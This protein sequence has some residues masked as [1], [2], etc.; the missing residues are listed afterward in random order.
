VDV[1]K[2]CICVVVEGDKT[3]R[4]LNYQLL[5]KARELADGLNYQ[6]VAVWAGRVDEEELEC[7]CS[8][9][10]D[11]VY[12]GAIETDDIRKIADLLQTMLTEIINKKL[13]IF[14][15]TKKGKALAAILS[16]RFEVGLTAEC[17]GIEYNNGFVY[18]RSA[19]NSTVM[20]EIRV[21]NSAFGMCTIKENTFRKGIRR[22]HH[23]DPVIHCT[24]QEIKKELSDRK[25]ILVKS[26]KKVP[27][28]NLINGNEKIVFGC[29]RGVLSA[30]CLD[31]FFQA[32]KKYKAE[33]ACTKPIAEQNVIEFEKQVG[34][35]G[36]NIAPHIY[37]AFGI[38]GT[39]QHIAGILNSSIIVAVNKAESAPIFQY[40]DYIIVA[41]VKDVLTEM[42]SSTMYVK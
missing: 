11:T 37:V 13:V 6:V 3:R 8:Y 34:Q 29:G 19:M 36:K 16:I 21:K 33:I 22:T 35:S 14:S 10:A 42:L 2:E 20:A 39:S 23:K 30:G 12:Y 41:D 4:E 25:D 28:E 17:I 7:L 9:G 26:I 38:S 5:T 1:E 27:K 40:S 31:L 15:S 18:T 32:A 24:Y